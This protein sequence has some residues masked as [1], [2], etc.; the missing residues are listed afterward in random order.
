MGRW[1]L[2]LCTTP[3]KGV[4]QMACPPWIERAALASEYGEAE[5]IF[6]PKIICQ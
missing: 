3:E 1:L 4:L 5:I 2:N 6:P